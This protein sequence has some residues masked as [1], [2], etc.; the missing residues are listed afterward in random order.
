MKQH[1]KV[2]K[3]PPA[4]PNVIRDV[5]PPDGH[6]SLVRESNLGST[7][8]KV[9]TKD[10]LSRFRQ[11]SELVVCNRTLIY[12]VIFNLINVYHSPKDCALSY[13]IWQD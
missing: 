8:C 1:D 5:E 10:I 13:L 9:L 6:A 12:Y 2:S 7:L 4:A 3:D 11:C